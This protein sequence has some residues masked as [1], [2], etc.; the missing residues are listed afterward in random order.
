ME[1]SPEARWEEEHA[2]RVAVATG[3]RQ[4]FLHFLQVGL[5]VGLY[6]RILGERLGLKELVE[7]REAASQVTR[8]VWSLVHP[9]LRDDIRIRA[10]LDILTKHLSPLGVS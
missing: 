7:F 3:S 2:E 9:D 10:V 5:G 8:T 6:P 4:A 1:H